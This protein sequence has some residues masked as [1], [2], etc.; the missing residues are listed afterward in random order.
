MISTLIQPNGA[1]SGLVSQADR[2][3]LV[4]ESRDG[5]AWIVLAQGRYEVYY[6]VPGHDGWVR[7]KRAGRFHTANGAYREYQRVL[8]RRGNPHHGLN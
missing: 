5:Y 8:S 2:G 3:P 7:A 4:R 1:L 6:Q